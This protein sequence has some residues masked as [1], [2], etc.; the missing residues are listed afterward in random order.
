[1]NSLQISQ[2]LKNNKITKKYF[3]GVFSSN[4]IPLFT[5]FPHCFIANT[6]RMGLSG[7]HWVALYVKNRDHIEY[8]CSLALPVNE[9]LKKYLSQF[10]YKTLNCKRLQSLFAN[11]CGPYCI[12]YLIYRC[13]GKSFEN[14]IKYL[15][16]LPNIDLFVKSFVTYKLLK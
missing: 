1:M 10:K 6:Q 13:L 9:D 11:T 14:I 15:F 5:T 2:I 12:F 4:N 16:S 3:K 8:F 7:E